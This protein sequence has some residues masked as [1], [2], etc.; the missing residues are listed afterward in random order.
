MCAGAHRSAVGPGGD[1]C[2]R[3]VAEQAYPDEHGD[4]GVIALQ[5]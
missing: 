4:R 3:A 5:C 1:H 2:G